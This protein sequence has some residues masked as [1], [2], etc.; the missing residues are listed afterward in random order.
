LTLAR[1]GDVSPDQ[2]RKLAKAKRSAV[3][4]G[5][6]PAAEKA[7]ARR[8][9][10]LRQ[11]AE[12]FLREH[13]EAKRKPSTAL[14]YRGILDRH[15]LPHLGSRKAADV[16]AA[17]LARLHR[18]MVGYQYQAN[19]MIAVV[20]SL[21]TF[22][23]KQRIVSPAFVNPA[24]DVER[25]R[26]RRR[27]RF[28]SSDEL[29]RL[30]DAIR[31]AETLG[32]PYEVDETSPTAKHAPKG[33]KRRANL[34]PLG[35]H[36]GAAL[37]LL[38][39]TGARLREILHLK[40]EHVDAECGV[41]L[42]RESKTG[43]KAIVL[44]APALA[45]LA[46]VPRIGCYV[47]A[48]QSAGSKNEKPRADLKAPWKAVRK[49][50]RLAGVR[51]HDLRHTH[52]SIGAGAGLG[53]PIIGKLLGHTQPATTHRYAHLDADPLRKASNVIGNHI[54]KA[55]G[56]TLASTEGGEVVQMCAR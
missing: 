32:L 6:D 46:N 33:N 2:A 38:L 25:Y 31:E 13:V 52:A 19:R 14:S 49:R 37:R 21:Y 30:G 56:E 9:D 12:A 15:V 36:A 17:D 26:E 35:P 8:A 41:L 20:G 50:A 51:I 10:T 1:V 40:W 11:A 47:I 53:L 34:S 44:N 43:Q 54:A 22:A 45:V 23:R 24:R 42:L 55:M 39:F 7:A 18:K 3:V 4:L 48:G 29:A 5:A 16:T 27:E 28:L